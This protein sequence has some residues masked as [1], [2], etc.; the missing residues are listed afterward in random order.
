MRKTNE[1]LPDTVAVPLT[2]IVY[3]RLANGW[4]C[5]PSCD[6]SS[7]HN[8]FQRTVILILFLLDSAARSKRHCLRPH[9]IPSRGVG[10]TEFVGKVDLL[11]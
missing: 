6:R 11:R 10:L 8:I 7:M 2:L 5:W 1:K 9:R 4:L 3:I